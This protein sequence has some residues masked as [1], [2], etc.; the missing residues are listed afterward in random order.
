MINSL[1][2]K[3]NKSKL[4]A[5]NLINE[6]YLL[7]KWE[8]IKTFSIIQKK[9]FFITNSSDFNLYRKFSSKNMLEKYTIK[10]GDEKVCALMDLKIYKDCVYIINFDIKSLLYFDELAEKLLQTAVEKALYN[11]T[12][13]EV[14]I[15]LTQSLIIKSKLKKILIKSEFFPEENQSNYEK[16]M[17]GE[18]FCIKVTNNSIWQKKIK[19]MPVLINR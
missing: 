11:T 7:P 12:E 19:Q 16:N 17:F 1:I 8:K 15:N 18:T 14:K 10:T 9:L 2:N 5:E 13:E 3:D 6:I 4:S